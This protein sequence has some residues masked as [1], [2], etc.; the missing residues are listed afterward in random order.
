[1]RRLLF[2]TTIFS[3]LFSQT[4]QSEIQPIWDNNCTSSCHI[5]SSLNGGL[6]LSSS[7][8][9]SELVNVASQGWP[10]FMRVKPGDAMNSVL[11]QKIVGNSSFGDRMPKGGGT[12]SQADEQKIK[13]WIDNGA[14]QDWSGGTS[15][16]IDVT[17]KSSETISGKP[18]IGLV[19]PGNDPNYWTSTTIRWG[20]ADHQFPGEYSAKVWDPTISD[21]EYHVIVFVDQDGGGEWNNATEYGAI[22]SP[23]M[24]A[25]KQGNAGTL[26]LQKLGGGGGNQGIN[27]TVASNETITMEEIL[28]G[29]IEPGNDPNDWY[30]RKWDHSLGNYTFPGSFQFFIPRTD[31]VDATGYH[32][33][34]FAD[35]NN[36]YIMT[37]GTEPN[38][39]SMAFNITGGVGNAGTIGLSI[40][41]GGGDDHGINLTVT[42]GATINNKEILVGLM[43]SADD[44][45]DW[46]TRMWDH[47]L[48]NY[49]FPGS[50]QFFI[51][52]TDLVDGNNY[53][54]YIFADLNNDKMPMPSTEPNGASMPF[55]ISEGVGNAGSIDL[56]IAGI[57]LQ[58]QIKIQK[59]YGS[60]DLYL[61][62]NK[63]GDDIY[64]AES[65]WGATENNV[66]P[67]YDQLKTFTIEGLLAENRYYLV[68]HFDANN[69]QTLDTYYEPS[70]VS[71]LFSIPPSG[72]VNLVINE[73]VYRDSVEVVIKSI[74]PGLGAGALW[75][76]VYEDENINPLDALPDIPD[77]SIFWENILTFDQA[78][79]TNGIYSFKHEYF[80]ARYDSGY[81]WVAWYDTGGNQYLDVNSDPYGW[82]S[83]P[84][85]RQSIEQGNRLKLELRLHFIE[86][87]GLSPPSVSSIQ[88]NNGEDLQLVFGTNVSSQTGSEVDYAAIHYWNGTGSGIDES[89][90][91]A[92]STG[93]GTWTAT[94]PGSDVTMGGLAVEYSATDKIGAGFWSGLY[95]IQVAFGDLPDPSL[96]AS[97]NSK[98]YQMVSVP[99]VLQ[100]SSISGVIE[101]E[102]GGN[103]PKKW[104]IFRWSNGAYQENSGSFNPGSAFWLITKNAEQINTGAGKSTLLFQS[105][106]L[107][108]SAG[109]NMVGNP[110]YFPISLTQNVTFN[111]DVEQTLYQWNGTGYSNATTMIPRGGNWIFSNGSGS[112]DFWPIYNPGPS[113]EAMLAGK[114]DDEES[115]DWKADLIT[116]VG[117]F[118]DETA[119]F[120]VHESASD[121]WDRFDYHEPPVIGDY[122][123][124][125][126]ENDYW[127]ENGGRYSQDIQSKGSRVQTWNLAARTNIKGIVSLRLEN[128]VEIPLYQDIRL[129]D[130]AMGLVYDLRTEDKVTF[131][132]QGTENPYYFQLMVGAADDIQDQLDVRGMI[133]NRFELAQN[134]PNPFNPVTNI[135]VSLIEDA[136]IT[137]RVYN[138]LGEEM[139]TLAL[140]RALGKGNHR[141]IWAGKDDNGNQLPSGV[142][143]YRM[144][145]NSLQGQRLYQ[146]TKKMILMK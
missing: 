63:E 131:T 88:A 130:T 20:L 3:V 133:P 34:V 45:N 81:A 84:V 30:A 115:F 6:N 42:S 139:N 28:V 127:P 113:G 14:P 86:G 33:I 22:S 54:L 70:G 35:L 97:T 56:S 90:V 43:G 120:G 132:S 4:Y 66:D 117:N 40:G 75:L 72:P 125:A 79:V 101:D 17:F 69:D 112:M 126:F 143:L 18:W 65:V 87:P 116:R 32:L 62:V 8:S 107:N 60:G 23:F 122:I 109:W 71:E 137:L 46:N 26:E 119:T 141:F 73:K 21:G 99:A 13:T 51:S 105:K 57:Q 82:G 92:V 58:A 91:G 142:Y 110:Y 114:A 64:A 129:V 53:R 59:E 9:Y 96:F 94:I 19:P 146:S 135:R 61:W 80:D 67:P 5:S 144:E 16:G 128:P 11:H 106:R 68:G 74:A 78:P 77:N 36:D 123:S 48:G 89:N 95:D 140:N 31:L 134:T 100:N 52:R 29:L 37:P 76:A 83:F 103:D 118:H 39:A 44:P 124:M 98:T 27:L 25:N 145:V 136:N 50:Y 41:G 138:L 2:I 93:D 12:L 108:L 15:E 85:N 24:V 121:T 49:T 1:M 7:N 55:D 10:A 47:S 102:L 104:R 111:G 38:G